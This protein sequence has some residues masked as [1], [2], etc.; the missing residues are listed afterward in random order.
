[1]FGA[2]RVEADFFSAVVEWVEW[3]GFRGDAVVF[4]T[5]DRRA[6]RGI[7]NCHGD[8]VSCNGQT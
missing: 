7:R 4:C 2:A 3:R 1:M 6:F 8:S 5:D